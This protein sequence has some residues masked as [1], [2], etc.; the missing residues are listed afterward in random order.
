MH[1]R[2][3]F[4]KVWHCIDDKEKKSYAMKIIK[5]NKTNWHLNL[6]KNNTFDFLE[7]EMAI[8]K[9]L[10]SRPFYLSGSS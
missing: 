1:F 5:K 10:V 2:G 3:K 6:L 7:K 8:M 4:A 9:K